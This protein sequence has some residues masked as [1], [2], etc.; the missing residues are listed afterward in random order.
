MCS[1]QRLLYG[2]KGLVHPQGPT[3][4]RSNTLPGLSL[5]AG[6]YLSRAFVV[7]CALAGDLYDGDCPLD[8][9]SYPEQ[10]PAARV[11]AL[12]V[13]CATGFAAGRRLRT[14]VMLS[15]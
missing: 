7:S 4:G 13:R 12:S 6:G 11:I 1:Y 5:N 3:P 8:Q 10:R 9:P 14:S 2:P 15:A